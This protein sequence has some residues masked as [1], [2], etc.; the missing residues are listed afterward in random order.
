MNI[1]RAIFKTISYRILGSAVSFGIGFL[2]TNDVKTSTIIGLGDLFVK[3]FIYMMHE[4]I[5]QKFPNS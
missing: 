3:P 1:K 4:L 2:F 5:W